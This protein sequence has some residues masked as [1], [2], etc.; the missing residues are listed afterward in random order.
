MPTPEAPS[1]F[2][3]PD[4]LT[5]TVRFLKLYADLVAI[6]K[7]P[8]N[9]PVDPAPTDLLHRPEHG[10]ITGVVVERLNGHTMLG[11]SLLGENPRFLHPLDFAAV[12]LAM[13]F[14]LPL[15]LQ[16]TGNGL[17]YPR[18]RVASSIRPA[19]DF[20]GVRPQGWNVYL[21]RVL[22]DAGPWQ[23]VRHLDPLAEL[24]ADTGPA[25]DHHYLGRD[26]LRL[27]S[28]REVWEAGKKARV[29][30]LGRDALRTAALHYYD[31][32]AGKAGLGISRDLYASVLDLA[33]DL[34]DWRHGRVGVRPNLADDLLSAA[35]VPTAA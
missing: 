28:V 7:H 26:A 11:I 3:H 9:L 20:E 2:L 18:F 25:L 6:S 21:L 33:W 12:R 17:A 32:N 24:G 34:A 35:T 22:A 8:A 15:T 29:P 4:A 19:Q 31:L 16:K 27:G 1:K 23:T 14:G 10:S 13:A 30:K 5:G